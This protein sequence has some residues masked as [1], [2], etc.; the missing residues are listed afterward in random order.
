MAWRV[1]SL[2]LELWAL[3]WGLVPF[4]CAFRAFDAE[5]TEQKN[6]FLPADF[7]GIAPSGAT[8]RSG[9]AAVC[10][11][12][13]TSSILV[14]ASINKINALRLIFEAAEELVPAPLTR[15]RGTQISSRGGVAALWK[16]DQRPDQ[17][18]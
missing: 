12:V 10:K 4:S 13:Y 11:T 17:P 5:G 16:R 9:Y 2:L 6:W 8:W 3:L 14:V 1:R 7:S 18:V 15:P